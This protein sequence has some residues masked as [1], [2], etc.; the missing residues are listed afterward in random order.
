MNSVTNAPSD[1]GTCGVARL[2]SWRMFSYADEPLSPDEGE[3]NFPVF[4]LRGHTVFDT[5]NLW[6][7]RR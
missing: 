4:V 1:L 2:C 7:K 5:A 3:G 6:H